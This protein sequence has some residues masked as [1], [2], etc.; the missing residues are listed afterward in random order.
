MNIGNVPS[1]HVH[2]LVLYFPRY[3]NENLYVADKYDSGVQIDVAVGL[4]G[5]IRLLVLMIFNVL[6]VEV[7]APAAFAYLDTQVAQTVNA[8]SAVIQRRI[9]IT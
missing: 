1:F 9:V 6:K 3:A 7:V 8:Q 5:M 4:G 2:A